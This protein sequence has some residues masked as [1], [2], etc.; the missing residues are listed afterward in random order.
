[1]RFADDGARFA[2]SVAG[3]HRLLMGLDAYFEDCQLQFN[4]KAKET[5]LIAFNVPVALLRAA[6]FKLS[7][8]KTKTKMY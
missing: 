6:Q 2:E 3:M 5:Q 7:K 8:T 4:V 1:V